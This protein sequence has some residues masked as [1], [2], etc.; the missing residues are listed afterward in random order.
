MVN[1]ND[2]AEKIFSLL[3]GY[4]HQ[5]KLYDAN[6]NETVDPSESRRMFAMD[7]GMMV[8]LDE[9]L[10]EL[11]LS[12]G[13]DHDLNDT[14]KLQSVLR[15]FANEYL[16]NYTVK[17]FDKSIQPRDFSYQAKIHRNREM[18]NVAEASLSRLGGSKKTSHQTL[19]NVKILVK[20]KQAVDEDKH[21]AR[22]RNIQAIFLERDGER[23]RFPSKN[24]GAA[25]SM[26]RHMHNGGQMND[27]IGEHII[28]KTQQLTKLKE[29]YRYVKSNRL[30]NEDSDGIVST[31]YESIQ[32]INGDL[33]RL[34]GVKTYE[35]M[36]SKIESSEA[37]H[38]AEDD[39][40]STLR[41]MFTVKRFDEKFDDVLP[42]VNQLVNEKNCYLGRIEEASG[43]EITVAQQNTS[44]ASMLEFASDKARL[45]YQLSEVASR[46]IENGELSSYLSTVGKKLC[47]EGELSAFESQIVRSALG[48]LVPQQINEVEDDELENIQESVNFTKFFDKYTYT[49]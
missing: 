9:E 22:S 2:L 17:E 27:T 15:R 1:V 21:G 36:A 48:N 31:I 24:L 37:G 10:N 7:A 4:G 20:H 47:Q 49:F 44:L 6:G 18:E 45:G 8:T 34:A 46:I 25:R 39:N 42:L 40:V 35:A 29:F 26:A 12:I 41:D 43:S 3:K 38:I 19:E 16:M 23:F 28:E 32:V 30:V 33:K 5:V 11:Q 13:A 14:R